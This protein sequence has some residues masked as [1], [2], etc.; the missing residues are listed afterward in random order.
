MDTTITFTHEEYLKLFVATKGI[1]IK[2]P[3][4]THIRNYLISR[5]CS[6]KIINKTSLRELENFVFNNIIFEQFNQHRI[7]LYKLLVHRLPYDVIKSKTMRYR[8]YCDVNYSYF[9]RLTGVILAGTTGKDKDYKDLQHRININKDI[10]LGQEILASDK[11]IYNKCYI[12]N[13]L[14]LPRLR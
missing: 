11:T 5:G 13:H 8:M 2:K 14:S 12:D 10:K 4:L 7:E 9:G 1:K 3:T 6:P